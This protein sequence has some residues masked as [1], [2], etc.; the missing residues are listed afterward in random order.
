MI[1]RRRDVVVTVGFC[2]FWTE[3]PLSGPSTK[4]LAGNGE[5][6]TYSPAIGYNW[7]CLAGV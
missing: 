4:H 7:L 2:E 1:A 5:K 6:L 3:R